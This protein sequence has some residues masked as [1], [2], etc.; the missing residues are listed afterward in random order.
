MGGEP[1]LVGWLGGWLYPQPI[2]VQT[3]CLTKGIA[4]RRNFLSVR[5]DVP[6]DSEAPVVTFV[7]LE[8]DPPAQFLEGAHRGRMCVCAFIGV[9]VCACI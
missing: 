2:R 9:S 4:Y 1:T 7:N 3:P 5:G 8:T 6:V